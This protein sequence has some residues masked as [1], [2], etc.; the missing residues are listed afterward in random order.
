MICRNCGTEI[1]DKALVCYRCG[2]AT[3]SPA[4]PEKPTR[5]SSGSRLIGP[6]V[7]ALVL[8]VVAA[9]YMGTAASGQVP[10]IAGWM[11]AGVAALVVAWRLLIRRGGT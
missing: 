8:L 1:A 10:R 3:A 6:S 7:A 5:S 11:V 4:A 9:L 2:T